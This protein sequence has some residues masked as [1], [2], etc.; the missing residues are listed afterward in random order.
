MFTPFCSRVARTGQQQ[1]YF[2]RTA[3]VFTSWPLYKINGQAGKM[4]S[5]L[6]TFILQQF[7]STLSNFGLKPEQKFEIFILILLFFGK[8][9]MMKNRKMT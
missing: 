1:Q 6:F 4:A 3:F 9:I 5:F 8:F 7:L 2:S